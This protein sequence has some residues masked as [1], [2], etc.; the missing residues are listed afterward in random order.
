MALPTAHLAPKVPPQ[1]NNYRFLFDRGQECFPTTS[2][3]L[4]VKGVAFARGCAGLQDKET[5]E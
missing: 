2:Q 1:K 5:P 3:G 4:I